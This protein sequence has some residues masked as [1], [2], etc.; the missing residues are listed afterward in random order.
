MG[1]G[2]PEGAEGR[3]PAAGGCARTRARAEA[4]SNMCQGMCHMV[5]LGHSTWVECS[6]GQVALCAFS[7]LATK[8][9]PELPLA[10]AGP[11]G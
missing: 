9:C 1:P 3:R 8:I 10:V 4:G 5:C 6:L 11:E 7:I 2:I